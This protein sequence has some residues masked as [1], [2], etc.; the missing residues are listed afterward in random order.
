MLLLQ[1]SLFNEPVVL[2]NE[3]WRKICSLPWGKGDV[4]LIL[5]YANASSNRITTQ[6]SYNDTTTNK[7]KY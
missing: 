6:V 3:L 4:S 7:R 1:R 5:A 2:T